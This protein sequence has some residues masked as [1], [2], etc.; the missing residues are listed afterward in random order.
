MMYK[1]EKQFKKGL[2][3]YNQ[4]LL[5]I[6]ID[7]NGQLEQVFWDNNERFWWYGDKNNQF[8]STTEIVISPTLVENQKK[9][10]WEQF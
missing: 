6:Y 9:I 8:Y 2:K 3:R 5:P 1:T 10:S 4:H 7:V